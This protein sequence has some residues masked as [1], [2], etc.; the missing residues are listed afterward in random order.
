MERSYVNRYQWGGGET[1]TCAHP[2]GTEK[3][4]LPNTHVYR[5]TTTTV[6]VLH[7]GTE[8]TTKVKTTLS[9][10]PVVVGVGVRTTVTVVALTHVP[11]CWGG[12][13]SD[14]VYVRVCGR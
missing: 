4:R 2:P 3:R 1:V 12:C 13:G 8:G 11:G 10:V 7:T 9:H 14:R 6:F 5:V